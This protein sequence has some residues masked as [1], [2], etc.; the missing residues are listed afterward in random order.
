[1]WLLKIIT[2]VAKYQEIWL[3]IWITRIVPDDVN[4]ET[5]LQIKGQQF[6]RV[7]EKSIYIGLVTMDHTQL[8]EAE[9]NLE[10]IMANNKN[11][12]FNYF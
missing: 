3:E 6:E 9:C 12:G 10:K 1:M 2:H 5:P 7:K 4:F 11:Y 8:L